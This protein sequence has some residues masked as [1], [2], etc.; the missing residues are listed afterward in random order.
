MG[1][2][3]KGGPKSGQ[4]LDGCLRGCLICSQSIHSTEGPLHDMQCFVTGLMIQRSTRNQAIFVATRR[5]RHE[6]SV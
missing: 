4:M 3:G 1:R 2:E 6:L 5:G